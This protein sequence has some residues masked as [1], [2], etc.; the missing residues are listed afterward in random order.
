MSHEITDINQLSHRY[1]LFTLN[2]FFHVFAQEQ[3]FIL[4]VLRIL[5]PVGVQT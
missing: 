2:L 4:K 3:H 5:Y 1:F